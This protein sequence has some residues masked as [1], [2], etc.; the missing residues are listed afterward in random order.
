MVLAYTELREF[1]VREEGAMGEF[2]VRDA[3]ETLVV[4]DVNNGSAGSV[5]V[6]LGKATTLTRRNGGNINDGSADNN[7]NLYTTS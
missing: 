1:S 5:F 4:R 3:K 7:N 6:E 2:V